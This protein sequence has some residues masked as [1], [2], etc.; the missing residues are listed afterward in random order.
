[1][2]P[3]P[4]RERNATWIHAVSVGE[5][6][7][8]VP[9]IR[10]LQ[11]R[12]RVLL[13]TTTPTGSARVR[14]L[15]GNSLTHVYLPYDLPDVVRRFLD[16][17]RPRMAIFMETEI[18]PNLF[19]GCGRRA[20]PLYIVN[21]RLTEKSARGYRRL[22]G[23]VAATLAHVATVCAQSQADAAR[24]V[25]L[26]LPEERLAVTGNLK[27][28]LT[29]PEDLPEQ[30]RTLR[31]NL[32][33][34]RPVW[35]AASTHAGE[36]EQVLEAFLSLRRDYPD[37]LLLLAPRH[38]ERSPEIRA[39]CQKRELNCVARSAGTPCTPGT[40]VF[41][42]DTLGELKLFYAAADIAFIGGSLVPAGGHNVLEPA[43]L[44]MP[45]LF[46]PL[47]HNFAEI[48][49]KL[50]TD[51]GAIQIHSHT[52]LAEQV[53]RLLADA[54]AR[55]QLGEKARLFLDANRGALAVTLRHLPGGA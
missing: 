25:L 35:I 1:L 53:S 54:T 30:G 24:F 13:T 32:F 41:I 46:G 43:A 20:I 23:L 7:A 36:E 26:G 2:Q 6:E 27:F 9:L 31:A 39:L 18:W 28:D 12:E 33:G 45:I 55:R 51:E 8:A 4:E 16:G 49:R 29:V 10:A 17:Y 22:R 52:E 37:L 14:A 47:M 5:V 40:A 21:A 11:A 42:L 50:L 38:P 48:S 3:I 19:A 15:F 44:G 34:R